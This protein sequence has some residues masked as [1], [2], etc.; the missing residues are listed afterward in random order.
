MQSS[1]YTAHVFVWVP[2]KHFPFQ[3]SRCINLFYTEDLHV[4]TVCNTIL[5]CTTGCCCSFCY[6]DNKYAEYSLYACFLFNSAH[7][8]LVKVSAC[9]SS[10]RYFLWCFWF[11][12][13]THTH[14]QIIIWCQS[15]TVFL[16]FRCLLQ[17]VFCFT[18]S[19]F[20]PAAFF[21]CLSYLSTFLLRLL[22][23]DT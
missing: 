20:Y 7:K 14:T 23:F 8:L 16:C 12:L 17:A 11:I 6:V 15:C 5:W 19:P 21:C 22:D 3:D 10:Y 4:S 2:Y 13:H 9:F 1:Q 18:F